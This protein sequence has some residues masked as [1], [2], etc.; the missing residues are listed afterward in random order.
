MSGRFVWHELVARDTAAAVTFYSELIGWK[1]ERLQL[2]HGFDGYTMWVGTQGPVG[3]VMRPPED[4]GVAD[5]APRWI[6]T[7]EIHDLDTTLA[8]VRARGGSIPVPLMSIPRV[9]RVAV[10]ADPQGATVQVLE[11]AP[12]ERSMPPRDPSMHGEVAWNE[13]H[14]SDARAAF[15]FYSDIFGWTAHEELDMGPDGAYIV[16]G[17]GERRCGGI[18]TRDPD[19]TPRPVWIHYIHVDDL[20][21]TMARASSCGARVDDGPLEVPDGSRVAHLTDPQGVLFALHGPAID[22]EADAGGM[23]P[24][25]ALPRPARGERGGVE[26]GFGRGRRGRRTAQPS[27]NAPGAPRTMLT[28]PHANADATAKS[29]IPRQGSGNERTKTTAQT[30]ANV[31]AHARSILARGAPTSDSP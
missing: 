4:R 18:M 29:T 14:A 31:P 17:Q 26:G 12:K 6:G 16:Y 20:E 23:P 30:I 19:M 1:S 10:I 15:A 27:R 3:G 9:G 7:V 21:S 11:P 25:R 24:Q 28:S 8:K 13:L 22:G 2:G 5:V